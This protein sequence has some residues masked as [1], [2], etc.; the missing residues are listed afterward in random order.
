MSCPR[1]QRRGRTSRPHRHRM[2]IATAHMPHLRTSLSPFP[3]K[4]DFWGR[5]KLSKRRHYGIPLHS[6][7]NR[8]RGQRAIGGFWAQPQEISAKAGVI[9]GAERTRTACQARSRYRT[10][11]SRSSS[12]RRRWTATGSTRSRA[13]IAASPPFASPNGGQPESHAAGE[14]R[15]CAAGPRETR[16][17]DRAPA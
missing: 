9:G 15:S 1:T 7:T 16:H 6:E 8:P 11:L 3:R 12:T 4:S 5:D 14:D 2:S 13:E 17:R 10:G